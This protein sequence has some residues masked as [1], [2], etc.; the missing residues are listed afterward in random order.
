MKYIDGFDTDDPDATC[1]DGY[2][3]VACCVQGKIIAVTFLKDGE[4]DFIRT[5]D[6]E[7]GITDWLLPSNNN[8]GETK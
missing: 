1:P 3:V 2:E 4:R 7:G 8:K 5:Y 6:D